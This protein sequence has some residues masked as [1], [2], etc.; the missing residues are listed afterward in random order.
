LFT[1]ARPL[2]LRGPT[3]G[4]PRHTLPLSPW[5]EQG[6]PTLHSVG[7]VLPSGVVA[8]AGLRFARV[9]VRRG[10]KVRHSD[11]ATNTDLNATRS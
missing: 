4:V 10:D 1:L 9:M 6:A 7:R 5:D 3:R 11:A 2:A 8:N